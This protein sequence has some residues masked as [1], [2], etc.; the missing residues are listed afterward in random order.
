MIDKLLKNQILGI[1]RIFNVIQPIINA[2]N[3]E[4]LEEYVSKLFPMGKKQK[5]IVFL[6]RSISKV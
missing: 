5:P 3:L 2:E 4:P 1:I 6:N